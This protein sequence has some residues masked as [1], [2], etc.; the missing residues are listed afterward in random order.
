MVSGGESILL[1]IERGA[2]QPG[3][4]TKVFGPLFA[5]ALRSPRTAR[6]V[7]GPLVR[8]ALA[9]SGELRGN[10]DANATGLL[11]A[12]C[13]RAE[14]RALA[15]A[16]LANFYDFVV[17]TAA[18][19]RLSAGELSAR[20]ARVEGEAAYRAVRAAGRGC[21]VVTAHMGSFEIGLAALARVERRVHVVFRRDDAAAFE[22]IRA[23]LRR[24]FGIVEAPI[25]DG[26]ATW[27]ALRDALRRDE[28]VVMQGD[29]ALDGQRS[30]VMPFVRGWLRVPTGPARLALL[31]G[32]PLVPAVTLRESGDTFAVHML[33][34]VEATR[35]EAETTR[36]VVGALEGIVTE[37]PAQWLALHRAF[38]KDGADA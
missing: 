38:E 15:R 29:R 33:K 36:R 1:G 31:A 17:D 22:E 20:I 28:V 7:R 12:G 27:M 32:A 14:R 24:G 18:A 8:M 6:A 3:S 11:G 2:Q 26:L 4:R 19:A 9:C 13:S 35:D 30:I 21:V 5:L 23:R 10:L 25:D 16:A 37:H 34:A